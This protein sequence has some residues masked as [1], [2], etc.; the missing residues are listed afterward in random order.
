MP[1][2][3]RSKHGCA[4][5]GTGSPAWGRSKSSV[6]SKTIPIPCGLSLF[7]GSATSHAPAV[8]AALLRVSGSRLCAEL[9]QPFVEA[10]DFSFTSVLD[11]VLG[12]LASALARSFVSGCL[13]G[14]QFFRCQ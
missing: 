10:G 7:V 9:V 14:A 4:F 12:C 13:N 8:G 6:A 5:T 2:V 11:E 3:L 1:H